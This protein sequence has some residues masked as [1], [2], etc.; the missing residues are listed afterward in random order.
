MLPRAFRQ[1]SD[2]TDQSHDQSRT[3]LLADILTAHRG[4]AV[5]GRRAQL[6]C[7]LLPSRFTVARLRAATRRA[8]PGGRQPHF[9]PLALAMVLR[10]LETRGGADAP[11]PATGRHG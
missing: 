4:P 6:R 3:Q 5:G 10:P 1:A 9:A 8:P 7:R 11:L 2:S